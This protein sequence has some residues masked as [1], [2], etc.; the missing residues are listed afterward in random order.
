MKTVIYLEKPQNLAFEL[1]CC[2]CFVHCAEEI[3]YL[4][5]APGEFCENLWGI[6]AGKV[7]TGE[8]LRQG[9]VRELKEETGISVNES[10]L[11]YIQPLFVESSLIKN[12]VFHMFQYNVSS[13]P[14]VRLSHEHTAFGWL[15]L[16]EIQS[17]P[18]IPGSDKSLQI[19]IQFLGSD[20]QSVST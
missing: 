11:H 5:K 7:K 2:A 9:I 18:L 4:K 10:E 19:Y 15:S 12:Y 1:I 20:L 17:L 14:Q 3:L 13:K 8:T 6:P 16:D